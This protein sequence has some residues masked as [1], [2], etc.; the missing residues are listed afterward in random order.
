MDQDSI[1]YLLRMGLAEH[2]RSHHATEWAHL[3]QFRDRQ[4]DLSEGPLRS[5]LG[6]FGL[7]RNL[8]ENEWDEPLIK[9]LRDFDGNLIAAPDSDWRGF[10]NWDFHDWLKTKPKKNGKARSFYSGTTKLFWF[11]FGHRFP[12]YDTWTR[13]AVG[14]KQEDRGDPKAPPAR[15]FFFKLKQ[16]KYDEAYSLTKEAL[17]G[18]VAARRHWPAAERVLDKTLFFRGLGKAGKTGHFFFD[19][20][21]L[22]KYEELHDPK[23]KW[24]RIAQE[25]ATS[26]PEEFLQ[27]LG[28]APVRRVR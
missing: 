12:M 23:R 22:N 10:F 5:V 4:H 15:R 21:L 24:P 28:S 14:G 18:T 8:P 11:V 16:A 3:R 6:E 2:H 17:E 25:L 20:R 19:D 27:I 7:L 1:K 13:R 26:L 9:S